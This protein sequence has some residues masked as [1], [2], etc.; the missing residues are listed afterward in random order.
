MSVERKSSFS[1][2]S[3]SGVRDVFS[4]RLQIGNEKGRSLKEVFQKVKGSILKFEFGPV[5]MIFT[6]SV[7][8]V[9]FGFLYLVTFNQLATKGY[10][11]K[12]LDA[13]H[14]QLMNQYDIKNMKTAQIKS[15]NT[16]ARTDRVSVMVKPSKVEYVTNN[17]A[18]ASL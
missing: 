5:A 18:L 14:Q 4:G 1:F 13:A 15:L 2:S 9:V 16:I 6:L 17:T 12:R 7:F 10:D 8:V 3:G 11:L